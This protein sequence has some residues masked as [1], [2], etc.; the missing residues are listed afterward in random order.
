MAS[1]S[2][3][4][5]RTATFTVRVT[6]EERDAID[7]LA[8]QRGLTVGAFLRAAALGSGGPRAKTRIPVDEALLRQLLGQIGKVGGNLN[9]IAKR[10]NTGGAAM[11][12]EV[13]AALAAHEEVRQAVFKAL[14]TPTR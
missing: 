10:L 3:L 14:R 12:S 13:R 1:G 6:P 9:Q 4:R 7:A 2:E 5:R 11:A 8:M